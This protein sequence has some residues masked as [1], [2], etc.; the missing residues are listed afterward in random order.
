MSEDN[1]FTV[2]ISAWVEHAHSD[3]QRYRE[4][5]ATEVL[6]VAVG[7]SESYGDRLY[8][9]GGILMGIVYQSPRQTVDIDFTAEFQPSDDIEDEL[10]KALDP[11]L[12]RASTRLGYPD[13]V[14]RVQRI[15]R[16]PR[17]NHFTD[18]EFPAL[19]MRIA[20]ATRGTNAHKKLEEGLCPTVLKIDIS[21]REPVHAIQFVRFDAGMPAGMRA[22]SLEDIIAEK[23]RAL[24]QQGVRNRNRRQDIY[25]IDYLVRELSPSSADKRQ[26]LSALL[27]KARARNIEPGPESLADPDIRRRAG[28]EWHTLALEIGDL[29]DFA[30]AFDRVETFYRGLPW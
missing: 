6:L 18:A 1:T 17:P 26:I 9:K 25:D 10:R 20:Y 27:T 19:S 2:D 8:L 28:A 7:Q 4:R 22:Y 21:F 14:L 12:M 13:L 23:L 15:E 24:L 5:Q 11:E 3:P 29:P 16:Q 30:D